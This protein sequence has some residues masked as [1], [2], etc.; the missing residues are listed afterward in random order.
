MEYYTPSTYMVSCDYVYNNGKVY[1]I[2]IVMKNGFIYERY[3][4]WMYKE[5]SLKRRQRVENKLK[6]TIE[7]INRFIKEEKC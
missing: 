6:Y 4:G 7:S 2:E 5:K 3:F 1:K